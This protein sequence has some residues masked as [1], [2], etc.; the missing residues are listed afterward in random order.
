[1]LGANLEK[2]SMIVGDN[3]AVVLNTTVP[4]YLFKKK[5]QACNYHKIRESMAGGFLCFG[6]I[7]S[8]E[9]VVDILTKL[10]PTNL[11]SNLTAKYLFRQA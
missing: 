2:E 1:M 6:H 7:P 10:L 4:S 11:F 3:M 8:E 9:K 5:H